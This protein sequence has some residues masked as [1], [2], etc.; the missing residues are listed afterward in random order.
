MNIFR[1][2]IR[3]GL[4]VVISLGV[5]VMLMLYLG[6]P[7]LFSG[8]K[9]FFIYAD[10]ASGLKQG[11]D[12]ALAGRRVGQVKK[13]TS[14][15]PE[16]ERPDIKKETLIE[17]TV[18]EN[19]QIYNEVRV[20]VAQNGLL[21]DTFIDFTNGAEDSGLAPN[22]K[23]FL[24]EKP[25]G[26]DQAVP[27]ILERLDPLLAKANVTL[28]NLSTT[29]QSLT[30]LT[31][32][33]GEIATTLVEFRTAGANVAQ[34]TGPGGPLK[35]SL[36]NISALTAPTSDLAKTLSEAEKLIGGLNRNEDIPKT[37]ANARKTTEELNRAVADLRVKFAAIADNLEQAT[38]T[39]K[40]QPWRLIWPST[41]RY[42]E[43]AQEPRQQPQPRSKKE[44][45]TRRNALP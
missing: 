26:L 21:G 24:G 9:T 15:V 7:G 12:V 2:E 41:K 6:A 25:A 29:A 42:P 37:L 5:L 19:A 45:T 8:Q 22:G 1:N 38:D 36:E 13:L 4:L 20:S 39:V 44:R 14:P 17:V 40:R 18:A 28:E 16:K 27:L 33:Q 30:R 10:N 3:T 32:P 11:A 31:S 34:L 43:D 23:K 35:S